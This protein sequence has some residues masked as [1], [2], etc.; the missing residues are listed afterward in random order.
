MDLEILSNPPVV[1]TLALTV[2]FLA[3]VGLRLGLAFLV[4]RLAGLV[5]VLLAV[6]FVTFIMGY[7][8]PTDIIAQQL[9]QHF[10]FQREAQ[11]RHF[12]GLDLPW[13]QQYG[14]FLTRLVH[15]D[16]GQSF[17]DRT[18]TVWQILGR[19]APISVQLGLSAVVLAFLVG[20]PLGLVAAVRAN[21]HYDTIIQSVGL[22]LI[23]VPHFVLIP[24]YQL[25]TLKLIDLGL[26]HL[27]T[28]GWGTPNQEIAPIVILGLT[29]FTFLT[30]LTRTSMLEVLRQ[31]YIRTARAKGLGR[32]AILWTHAFRNAMIP[33]ITALGPAVAFTVTGAFITES[34]FNIPGIGL[35]TIGAVQSGDFP[36]VQG[37]VI[38]LAVTVVI[39][40]LLVDVLYGIADPRIK[41]E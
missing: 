4:R 18:Q 31:D 39:M 10:T 25:L 20:V 23:A 16:L 34:K 19:Q 29:G 21:T 8:A 1:I 26:P 30:R 27:D 9:G 36:V 2:A 22:L 35:T 28:S 3:F 41:S 15:L 33:L 17:L 12:Y 7:Y 38:L 40:N 14:S 5:F 32:Q 11:L 6:T 24:Y 37:T 13:Y